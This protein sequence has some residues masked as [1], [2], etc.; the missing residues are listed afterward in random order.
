MR[1]ASNRRICKEAR[2]AIV[3]PPVFD[4]DCAV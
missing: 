2:F 1:A 4:D 3:E